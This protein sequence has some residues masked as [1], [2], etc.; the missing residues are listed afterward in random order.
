MLARGIAVSE[1]S[2]W[3]SQKSVYQV[4]ESGMRVTES[5]E[6]LPDF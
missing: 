5:L 4:P 1:I 3:K 2:H 6:L